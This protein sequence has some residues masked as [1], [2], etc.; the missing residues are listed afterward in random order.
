MKFIDK[1]EIIDS[2]LGPIW[3]CYLLIPPVFWFVGELTFSMLASL[4]IPNFFK[5]FCLIY[6]TDSCIDLTEKSN[7]YSAF[8]E[9]FLLSK[10]VSPKMLLKC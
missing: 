8:T 7:F 2:F 5:H 10:G 6:S 3:L 9:V 4:A 1:H